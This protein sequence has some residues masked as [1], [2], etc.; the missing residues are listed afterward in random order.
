MF[1]DLPFLFA[2]DRVSG[3]QRVVVAETKVAAE[4][5]L[6]TATINQVA[7]GPRPEVV[8]SRVVS[9]VMA[10]TERGFMYLK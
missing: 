10:I 3:T 1:V 8:D 5:S 7:E 9:V 4:N 2:H 6:G